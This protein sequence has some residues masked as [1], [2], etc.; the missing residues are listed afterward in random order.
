MG[1]RSNEEM[2]QRERRH[3]LVKVRFSSESITCSKSTLVRTELKLHPTPNISPFHTTLEITLR[4]RLARQVVA[5]VL[6]QTGDEGLER[7][8]GND[9]EGRGEV[10][11]NKGGRHKKETN[12]GRSQG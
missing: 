2:P 12:G 10:G 3:A 5:V 6:L 11:S 8:D 1:M 7:S 4:Q 9:A